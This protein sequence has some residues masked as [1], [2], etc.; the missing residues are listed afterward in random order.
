MTRARST[1]PGACAVDGTVV[2]VGVRW[3]AGG[4]TRTEAT[5]AVRTQRVGRP[6]AIAALIGATL[7]W[8][9]NYVFGKVAVATMS[10]VSLTFLRWLL[11]LVPLLVIAQWAERPDWRAVRRHW[12]FL[13]LQSALGLAGYN[14][15]LYSALTQTSA[16]AASLINAANPALIAIAALVVLREPLG[17]RGAFGIGLAFVGVLVI[18][19]Q[20]D[21]ASLMA[22]DIGRGDLLML[23]AITVWTG[24]TV[25]GR[26][27]PR[28]P[29]ITST[30]LQAAA[31][32]IGLGLAAPFVGG[33]AWP[34][35]PAAVASLV[36]IA[37][38]PSC[39]SYV[40][41]N[42][43]LQRVPPARAGVFLNLI[44]VFTAV[45]AL[46]MGTPITAAQVAGGL[47]VLAGVAL[48]AGTPAR[49]PDA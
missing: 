31:L 8:A 12:P 24:Y 37:I 11:A 46:A 19:T 42:V 45:A 39:A 17:V 21:L 44:T 23:G 14:L 27:G 43:A 10:P 35:E 4:A 18:L 22:L 2:P 16:L 41:W 38:F 29:P 20:G 25:A 3:G 13:L 40:L 49:D 6:A 30:A 47:T 32:V 34:S 5:G 36:F 33:V 26:L 1:P 9:G 7:F 48:T 28:L 15:L